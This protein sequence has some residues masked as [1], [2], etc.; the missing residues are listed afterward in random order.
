MCSFADGPLGKGSIGK[1]LQELCQ[2]SAIPERSNHALRRTSISLMYEAKLA[3][4]EIMKRTCHK[5]LEALRRYH[6]CARP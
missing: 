5:S 4:S 1:L 3:E 6:R 2:R